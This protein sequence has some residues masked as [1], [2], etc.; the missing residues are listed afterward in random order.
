MDHR[1]ALLAVAA[2]VVCLVLGAPPL[3]AV[4]GANVFA[5][6][7][8]RGLMWTANDWQRSH[9]RKGTDRN[10]IRGTYYTGVMAAYRATGDGAYLEQAHEW[11]MKH[12]WQPGTERVALDGR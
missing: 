12:Q 5:P 1:G 10:W 3:M 4:E 7:T 11:A 2:A 8:I 6:E 9:L